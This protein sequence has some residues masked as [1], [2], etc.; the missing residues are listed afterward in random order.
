MAHKRTVEKYKELFETLSG[1]RVSSK[2]LLDLGFNYNSLGLFKGCGFLI[3]TS[4]R[5]YYEVKKGIQ[6][7]HIVNALNE[8][9]QDTEIVSDDTEDVTSLEDF[10]SEPT[11]T[12][13]WYIEYNY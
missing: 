9:R 11:N 6:P 2:E 10:Y 1:K 13:G 12:M 4:V 5:G 8:A 7:I 3:S